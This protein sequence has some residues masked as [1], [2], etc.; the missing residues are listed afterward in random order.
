MMYESLPALFT[1]ICDAIR[2]KDGTTGLIAHQDIPGRISAISGGSQS[3]LKF[4]TYSG[5]GLTLDNMVASGFNSYYAV[6]MEESFMPGDNP[7]EIQVKFTW[8]EKLSK[9]A[10]VLFGSWNG[11]FYYCPTLE[12]GSD[13]NAMKVWAAVPDG[14]KAWNYTGEY[15]ADATPGADYWTRFKFDGEK[16]VV[17]LSAD[18][19]AFDDII[20]IDYGVMYQN[21]AYS[22]LQFGGINRSYRHYF[23]GNID[24]KETYIRIGDKIWWGGGTANIY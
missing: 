24:L 20:R 6:F 8:P 3:R 13:S 23:E 10:N 21:E 14:N 1:G 7:W 12:I 22:K 19:Q 18:G 17:S 5:G 15:S 16:Y 11:D 4:A 2:K 9:Y